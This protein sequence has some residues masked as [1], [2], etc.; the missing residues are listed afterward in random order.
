MD[1]VGWVRKRCIIIE[2]IFS[3]INIFSIQFNLVFKLARHPEKQDKLRTEIFEK[4]GKDNSFD[5]I[6]DLEYLDACI[7]GKGVLINKS[8]TYFAG[9]TSLL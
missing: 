7:H 1:V 5:A 8:Y 2:F 3:Q 6:M 9:Y 4:L